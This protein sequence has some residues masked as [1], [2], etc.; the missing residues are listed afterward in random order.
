MNSKMCAGDHTLVVI[1]AL[2]HVLLVHIAPTSAERDRTPTSLQHLV[3]TLRLKL[4]IPHPVVVSIVATNSRMVSVAAPRTTGAAFELSI[5]AGFLAELT[6]DELA[7]ALAHELGHVWVFT[8]HPYLQTERLAND[9]AMRVVT[10]ESL[11]SVYSKM[12]ARMG[13]TPDI[14][15]FLGAPTDTATQTAALPTAP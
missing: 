7:A 15:M 10:R 8:H 11:A 2:L 13:T 5:E 4:A 6:D 12:W 14:G 9:I 1:L 3:D